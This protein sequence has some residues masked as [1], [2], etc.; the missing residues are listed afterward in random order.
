M[1]DETWAN[2]AD[3]AT[4]HVV[5]VAQLLTDQRALCGYQP[6]DGHDWWRTVGEHARPTGGRCK[7]CLRK[8]KNASMRRVAVDHADV[9]KELAKR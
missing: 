5:L 8:F 7:R 3:G 2:V 1:T 9:L 4:S 6:R